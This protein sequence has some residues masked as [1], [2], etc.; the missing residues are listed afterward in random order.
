M[1]C[2]TFDY[3]EIIGWKYDILFFKNTERDEVFKVL[4]K[5]YGK[6]FKIDPSFY[7]STPWK[8]TG[9]FIN[10]SLFNVLTSI[11]YAENFDFEINDK[12]IVIKP[13]SNE[14]MK[15]PIK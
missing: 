8:Y 1:L 3:D 12:E 2:S 15:E 14:K 7:E 6:T 10:E 11:G 13:R 4:E 9:K 5:W